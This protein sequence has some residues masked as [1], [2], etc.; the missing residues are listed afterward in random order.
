MTDQEIIDLVRL[1]LG[2]ILPDRVI[3]TF[4]SME[5]I[6]QNYPAVEANLSLVIYNT[7]ILC[8]QWLMAQEVSSGESSITERL[9]KIGDETIHIKTGSTFKTWKDFLDWLLANPSYIDPALTAV[10][11]LVIIGG[12][13][14]NEFSRV[15]NGSNS[16][17]PF[18]VGGIIPTGG[19]PGYPVRHPRRR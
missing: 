2:E 4:L 10:G 19:I 9:E 11:K 15:K 8:V 6:R 1:L 18:D 14:E 12:V 5:K 13:R 7:M 16:R 17:G 3:Q